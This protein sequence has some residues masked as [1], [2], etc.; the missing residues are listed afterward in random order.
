VVKGGRPVAGAK[1]RR[2]RAFIWFERSV[3]GFGMTIVAFFVER[4]LLKALR[5]GSVKPAPRTAA[6]GEEPAIAPGEEP[7]PHAEVTTGAAT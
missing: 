7:R 3:L 1:K 2:S 6:A 4:K 5:A